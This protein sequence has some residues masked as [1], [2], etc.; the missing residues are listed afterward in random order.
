M[1]LRKHS[2]ILWSRTSI[3]VGGDGQSLQ[4]TS[5]PLWRE[6]RKMQVIQ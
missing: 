5:E 1:S 6:I 3:N 4:K 2:D